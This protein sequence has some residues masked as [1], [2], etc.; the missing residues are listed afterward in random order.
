[1]I[2]LAWSLVILLFVVGMLGA[3]YPVL[4]GV[5]AIY[6]AFFIYGWLVSFE[7]FGWVFWTT[8][9]LI[10][11]IILVA[12]YAVSA[13]GVKKFGGSRAAV[14]GSTIGLIIGPFVI[15]AF[16]LIIGPF[17]GAVIGELI[18]GTSWQKAVTAGI[19]SVLGFFAS[20]AVK[21]V[22]QLAMIILFL[23]WVFF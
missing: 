7:P 1:M 16:G 22:L 20:S 12:D 3:V 6:A 18:I 17:V 19:G 14:I 15:P 23:F 13:M 9:T 4:P 10:V 5:L 2:A 8:Q 11:I 21:I